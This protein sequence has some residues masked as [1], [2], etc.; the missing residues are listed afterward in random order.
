MSCLLGVRLKGFSEIFLSWHGVQEIKKLK[1]KKKVT[2][3]ATV[4]LRQ[5]SSVHQMYITRVTF[6]S[7][8]SV[9]TCRTV[10]QNIHDVTAGGCWNSGGWRGECFFFLFVS[11]PPPPALPA[12]RGV[13]TFCRVPPI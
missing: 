4:H 11:P 3:T 12:S 1:L 5:S 2:P 9:V 10:E 8:P 13:K 6:Q 7:L